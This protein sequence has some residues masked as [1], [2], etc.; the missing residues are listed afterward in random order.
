MDDA[1][2]AWIAQGWFGPRE[3]AETA[4]AAADAA[5]EA[6]TLGAVLPPVGAPPASASADGAVACFGVMARADAPWP[7]PPG[8]A[9]VARRIAEALVSM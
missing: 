7:D 3:V 6:G 4:K 2:E 9:P 8:L 5:C 1:G